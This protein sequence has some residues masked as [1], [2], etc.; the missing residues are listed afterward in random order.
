MTALYA[1]NPARHQR[2]IIAIPHGRAALVQLTRSL[3]ML[4]VQPYDDSRNR[5]SQQWALLIDAFAAAQFEFEGN[6]TEPTR[7]R[8]R[9]RPQWL[10]R[11]S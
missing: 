8:G 5:D 1:L 3:L 6:A 11:P 9:R 10:T 7:D 4:T 2:L